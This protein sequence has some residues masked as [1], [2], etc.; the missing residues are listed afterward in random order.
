MNRQNRRR[1]FTL[2]ELL[3]V[4]AIMATLMGLLLPAV[5]KVRE[6]ANRTSCKNNL[7]QVGL[8][9]MSYESNR[10]FFPPAGVDIPATATGNA[11]TI[12]EKI[13]A[14]NGSTHGWSV[15]M[16][17]YIEQDNTYGI[18]QFD[19]NWNATENLTATRVKVKSFLCPSTLDGDRLAPNS[20]AVND[21]API[22]RIDSQL[23]TASP[24]LIDNLGTTASSYHG[25][26]RIVYWNSATS[27]ELFLC[28]V[29]DVRDGTSNTILLAED[30][31]R[32]TK[33]TKKG[34]DLTTTVDGA[35]W[36]D[37]GNSFK[38]E[39]ASADGATWPGPCA[40]NCSNF[41][42]IYSFHQGGA[43]FV[44]ADGSVHFIPESTSIRIIGRLITRA[45]SEIV[46]SSDF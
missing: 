42:E 40:I 17:P 1:G 10:G 3:V 32:P 29:P 28:R 13:G 46:S 9:C 24:P 6:A 41:N 31:G 21:Y 26:M 14:R 43:T 23:T 33:W 4:M 5:Q 38:V 36:A 27:N 22:T 35:A 20:R 2:I 12:A 11:R 25:I 37:I 45:G 16:L 18:Y 15:F 7:R 30:A 19:K 8:A 34:A 44:F 39:G